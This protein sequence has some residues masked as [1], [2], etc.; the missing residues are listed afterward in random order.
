MIA[1]TLHEAERRATFTD[2]VAAYFRAHPHTWIPAIDLETVGGR[3]AWRSR[4][5]QCRTEFGMRIDNRQRTER[6]IRVSEY[7]YVPQGQQPLF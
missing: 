5:S 2:R 1:L 4:V 7:R 3:Q 6:G